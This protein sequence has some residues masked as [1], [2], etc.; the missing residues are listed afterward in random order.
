MTP[1]RWIEYTVAI[2]VGNA[3]YFLVLFPG[4]PPG[5]QHQP[6]DATHRLGRFDAGLILYFLS[7]VAVYGAIRLGS[8][9]ARRRLR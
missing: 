6:P 1:R 2:V 9:P 7:C 8:R 3:V 5:L 4:L